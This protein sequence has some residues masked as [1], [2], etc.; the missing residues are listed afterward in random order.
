MSGDSADAPGV[1]GTGRRDFASAVD[2]DLG[3]LD[4]QEENAAKAIFW[5]DAAL[6]CLATARMHPAF[7]ALDA[8]ILRRQLIAISEC[9]ICRKRTR[10]RPF[11]GVMRR[12]NVWRQRG[13]T[14]RSRHWTPRFCVGS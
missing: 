14:R 13:C 1:P 7:Q 10:L 3:M 11:S 12:S 6:K 2:C 9:S 5:R 8:A 4:L